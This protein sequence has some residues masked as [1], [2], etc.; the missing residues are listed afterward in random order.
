[1]VSLPGAAT[2]QDDH[3]YSL[4]DLGTLGG[5]DSSGQA[6]NDSGQVAGY[7]QT[8]SGQIHAFF[9]DGAMHDIGTLGGPSSRADDVNNAGEVIGE[10]QIASPA[11]YHAFLWDGS[12]HDLGTFG[13]SSSY[14][15]DINDVGQVVGYAEF[16]GRPYHAFLWD[17]TMHDL[18]TLGGTFS[19][20]FSINE[21]GQ[22]VGFA[23]TASG[24]AHAFL[25]DG[26]M[27]DLGTLGWAESQAFDINDSGQVAGNLASY[28]PTLQNHVFLWDGT[29]HDIGT[30]GG[31]NSYVD[32]DAINTSGEIAG[33]SQT[34]S[35][36]DHAFLWDGT[37]HDLGPFVPRG[38]NDAGQVAGYSFTD[39]FRPIVYDGAL[40]D[41]G[42]FGGPNGIAWAINEAGQVA[43]SAQTASGEHHAFLATP[44]LY[45]FLGFAAPVANP[46]SVNTGK[47]GRTY[48]IKWGLKDSNG[49]YVS[50]LSAIMGVVY[51]TTSCA[52]FTND[53]S[54]AANA[55][56]SGRTTLR[57]NQ[58]AHQFVYNWKTPETGCYTLFVVLDDGQ[59]IPAYFK[60]K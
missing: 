28:A 24:Q 60:L 31:S 13:G 15:Y 57:Y 41:L 7:S 20:A 29:M 50:S 46:P 33:S 59:A 43:G 16:F 48:A 25:W 56:P 12:M 35:G 1:M 54:G 22:V 18:G 47:A 55:A 53:P 17:G 52:M 37:M 9:W 6:I 58:Q 10:A 5:S 2:A 23:E 34:S 27:H 45:Q 30:L 8:A 14:A 40:H 39:H 21:A 44:E 19:A 36:D 4:T 42:T 11:Y 38:F 51:K 49:N 32:F 26:T 3:R